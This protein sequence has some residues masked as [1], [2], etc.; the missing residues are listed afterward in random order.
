MHGVFSN[1]DLLS[2][3]HGQSKAVEID[4]MLWESFEEPWPT[5]EKGL[6]LVALHFFVCYIVEVWSSTVS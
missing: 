3:S 4:C 5:L 2:T 6:L 1:K